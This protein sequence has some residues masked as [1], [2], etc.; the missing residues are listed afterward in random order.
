MPH[1]AARTPLNLFVIL[2]SS[3][4]LMACVAYEPPKPGT[5]REPGQVAAAE[6]TCGYETATASRF[7]A[8]RCRNTQDMKQAAEEAQRATDSIRTEPPNPFATPVR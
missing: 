3:S 4:L 1:T 5:H 8:M 6:V 2:A 7:I